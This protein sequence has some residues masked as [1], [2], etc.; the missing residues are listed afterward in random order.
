MGLVG[1]RLDT[2]SD[3]DMCPHCNEFLKKRPCAESVF[4][5]SADK[6]NMEERERMRIERNQPRGSE[7]GA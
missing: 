5:H 7:A 3:M 6:L 1:L 2:L 4:V